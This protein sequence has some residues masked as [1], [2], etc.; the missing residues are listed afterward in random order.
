M[1]SDN[2]TETGEIEMSPV[3]PR[4]RRFGL[5][6]QLLL[7]LLA[8]NLVSAIAYTTAIYQTS[9]TE[10]MSGIDARLEAGA[11]AVR[12]IVPN[13]YHARIEGEDSIPAE[14]FE[15]LRNRLSRFA[16]ASDFV[17]VYS[18]MKFGDEVRVIT[19][20][21]TPAEI[22]SGETTPFYSLYDTAPPELYRT[23]EDKRVRFDEYEDSFGRFRSVYLPLTSHSG[24]TYV[25]GAD[26]DLAT[27]DTRLDDALEKSILIGLAMF[28]LTM[29]VGWL[30]IMRIVEPLVRLTTFTRNIEQ[31]SFAADEEELAA[32]NQISHK[33]G[34]EVGSLAEA[35]AGMIARLQ[36]YLV[37]LE[38]ATA[39]RV[40]VE[41]ELSAAREIQVGMLPRKFPPFPDQADLDVYA[42]LESAKE[43]GG[44]LYDYFLIDEN[45]LFFVVGDVSGKG[46]PAALFMAMT[47]SLF[48]AHAMSGASTG[49]IMARVNE[50][51]SR[52]NAAEMFVT[53]FACI[54]DLRD[55]SV[56]YSDGGHEAP[57]IVRDGGAVER[58]EKHQGMAL[59]IFEDVPYKA[60]RFK[61]GK[62]DALVLFTDGVSEATNAN[63]DLFTTTRIETALATTRSE[64][65]AQRI[66]EGLSE[67]VGAFVGAVP[68]SDDIAILVVGYNG[69]P[70]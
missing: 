18:Y 16:E 69:Q 61:L 25:V 53:V 68:Q 3:E 20:S 5:K 28:A 22:A 38:A 35:M 29:G 57:F 21:N 50:E 39:A 47:T 7:L 11:Y 12:E 34:D 27:L 64:V 67:S 14:E 41:S 42:M 45:R 49:A 55:G 8:L 62:G 43:V 56:E 66:A 44:D 10:I 52:D 24:Q 36:S 70:G 60:D 32:M 54:L 23:F 4:T 40:R 19:T 6:P 17:Y 1:A 59:G 46:V 13:G 9:R 31:R 33:R 51:L 15:R 37:D 30:L 26:I 58:L 2:E 65:S 48:K 63:D